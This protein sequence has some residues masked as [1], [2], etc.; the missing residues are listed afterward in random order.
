MGRA[1]LLDAAIEKAFASEIERIELTV[2]DSNKNVIEFYRKLGFRY[3]GKMMRRAKMDGA[4]FDVQTMAL[5]RS[6]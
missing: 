1:R 6:P 5:L 2:F 3:E 4:Y